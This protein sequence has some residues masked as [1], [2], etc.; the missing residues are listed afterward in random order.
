MPSLRLRTDRS[1]RSAMASDKESL[2]SSLFVIVVVKI[3]TL[4]HSPPR[5]SY[6]PSPHLLQPL[7][8]RP[9]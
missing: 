7:P 9:S 4:C 3:D 2:L 8:E 5:P 1:A 6:I